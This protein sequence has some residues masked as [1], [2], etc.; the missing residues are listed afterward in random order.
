MIEHGTAPEDLGKDD[1][2]G[3]D[4]EERALCPDETCI[5]VI[6]PAGRCKVC[7]R[8]ADPAI[9]AQGAAAPAAPEPEDEETA[10]AP[11][12]PEGHDG[13]AGHE[14]AEDDFA[15]RRLC[16]DGACIGVIGWDGR[17]KVCGRSE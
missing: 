13:P 14:G 7:G 6:G 10:A 9:A 5:G 2:D 11:R 17:C 4:L 8:A 3:L 12:G 1:E 16:P 15:D